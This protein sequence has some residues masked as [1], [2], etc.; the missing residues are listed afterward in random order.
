MTPNPHYKYLYGSSPT[1]IA[2][3]KVEPFDSPHS[4]ENER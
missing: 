2:S 1:V 4:L 3:L